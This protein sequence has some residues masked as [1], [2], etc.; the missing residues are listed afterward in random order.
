MSEY[1]KLEE[2]LTQLLQCMQEGEAEADNNN[3]PSSSDPSS[4]VS[5]KICKTEVI[6]KASE[7]LVESLCILQEFEMVLRDKKASLHVISSELML[8]AL[9]FR[10]QADTLIELEKLLQSITDKWYEPCKAI[11]TE[12]EMI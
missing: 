8:N 12:M 10:E 6:Q 2:A 5:A 1:D 11:A 9:L 7:K 4:N 3:D